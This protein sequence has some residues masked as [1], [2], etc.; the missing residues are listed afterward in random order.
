MWQEIDMPIKVV[1]VRGGWSVVHG[2]KKSAKKTTK[3]KAE[4]QARLLRGIAHGWKPSKKR[5]R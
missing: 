5:K 2:G 3:A 4:A 1:K